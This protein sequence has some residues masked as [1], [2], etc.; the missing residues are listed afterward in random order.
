MLPDCLADEP[1][2]SHAAHTNPKRQRGTPAT[3]TAEAILPHRK[4][5][6]NEPASLDTIRAEKDIIAT[7]LPPSVTT[8]WP[9]V[10]RLRHYCTALK[11]RG[12]TASSWP[13]YY[14][15]VG[16][17]NYLFRLNVTNRGG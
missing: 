11:R 6:R 15:S 9:D 16:K 2:A 8:D 14:K 10:R 4:S 7:D 5:P 1:A 17:L 12:T 13:H 3:H